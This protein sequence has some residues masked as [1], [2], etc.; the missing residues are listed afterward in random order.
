MYDFV[1]GHGE[2]YLTNLIIMIICA[3]IW[4]KFLLWYTKYEVDK[5]HKDIE[6]KYKINRG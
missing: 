4:I 3:L 6:K 2:H 5:R 1:S